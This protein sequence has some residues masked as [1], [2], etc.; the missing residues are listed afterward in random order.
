MGWG[1]PPC[2]KKSTARFRG[3]ATEEDMLE[4]THAALKEVFSVW[5]LENVRGASSDMP[6]ATILRG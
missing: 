4:Q 5:A 1:S 3:E 2:K 6:G